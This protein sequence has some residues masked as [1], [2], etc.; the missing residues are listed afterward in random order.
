MFNILYIKIKLKKTIYLFSQ[1]L[2]L[3][4]YQKKKMC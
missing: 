4:I 1:N 3:K 2:N